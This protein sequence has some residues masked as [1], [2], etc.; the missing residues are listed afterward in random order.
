MNEPSI[1][2]IHIANKI[3]DS[4]NE[5][6]TSLSRKDVRAILFKARIP[7]ELHNN[8]LKELEGFGFIGWQN[9]R[10]IEVLSEEVGNTTYNISYSYEKDDRVVGLPR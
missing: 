3:K 5:F 10:K 8:F 9:K 2:H 1:F 6:E 7:H 4:C